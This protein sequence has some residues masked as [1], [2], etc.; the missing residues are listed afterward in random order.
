MALRALSARPVTNV[1]K[2]GTDVQIWTC[3]RKWCYAA[4]EEGRFMGW[5]SCGLALSA[6]H[7]M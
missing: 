5:F 3:T 6:L 1:G 4:A 2:A 7:L